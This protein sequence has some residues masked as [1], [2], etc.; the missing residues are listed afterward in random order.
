MKNVVFAAVLCVALSGF[1]FAGETTVV[2]SHVHLC[3]KSCV[4]GV[5]QAL[6]DVADVKFVIEKDTEKVTLTAKDNASAQAAVD[7]MAG[8]GYQGSTD[9]KD[10]VMKD[11][12][13]APEGKVK[14]L[15]VSNIHNC[16]GKCTTAIEK[17][18]KS[19]PG[20]ASTTAKPKITS[21]SVEG[22]FDAKAVVKALNDAGF[23]ATVK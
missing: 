12:S 10:V 20:V 15:E 18:I 19:V 23:H 4:D 22:D 21:F 3:C 11:N 16:C 13:G 2:V 9:S 7:A 1:V 6:K 8:A 17:A 14:K 5:T